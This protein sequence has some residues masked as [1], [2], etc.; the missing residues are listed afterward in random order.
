MYQIW[1][2]CKYMVYRDKKE[3]TVNM[4]NMY[5]TPNKEIV[6]VEMNHL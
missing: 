6:T 3:F 2:F 4:K 1:D 5:N